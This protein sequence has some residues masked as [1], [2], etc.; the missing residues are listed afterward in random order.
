M[1]R[2]P[3]PITGQLNLSLMSTPVIAVPQEKQKELKVA[4]ID[5]LT[6]AAYPE[7]ESPD[8]TTG[9]EDESQTNR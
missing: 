4:L 1:K 9:D 6:N 3:K 7:S 8:H 5:L 2:T